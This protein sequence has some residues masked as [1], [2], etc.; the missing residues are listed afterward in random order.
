MMSGQIYAE[1][2]HWYHPS[3]R[4]ELF[5]VVAVDYDKQLIEIQYFDGEIEELD[6]SG[7]KTIT[8]VEVNTPDE[9]KGPYDLNED[10]QPFIEYALSEA[11]ASS[12]KRKAS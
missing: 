4:E 11:L 8:P 7:W 9:W 5:E 2:G 10:D 12:K 1:I 3:D 6:F